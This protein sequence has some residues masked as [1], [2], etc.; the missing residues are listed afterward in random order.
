[1]EENIVVENKQINDLERLI[2]NLKNILGSFEKTKNQL[3]FQ[4]QS[5]IDLQNVVIVDRQVLETLVSKV[6]QLERKIEKDGMYQ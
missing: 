3:Y 1:M 2:A 4:A 6:N 5:I